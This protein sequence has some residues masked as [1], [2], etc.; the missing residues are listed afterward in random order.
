MIKNS[1]S[2]IRKLFRATALLL[3]L[4]MMLNVARAEVPQWIWPAAKAEDNEVCFFRKT[5]NLDSSF[6][7]AVLSATADDEIIVFV[8][9]QQVVDRK[10]WHAPERVDI[11]QHLDG[12][13]NVIAIRARNQGGD[14]AMIAMVE[15][16]R[17][18]KPKEFLYSD[19][20]WVCSKT[21]SPKWKDA[22]FDEAGWMKPVSRGKLG[23]EPWGNI[24][25]LPVATAVENITVPK[26][27]KVELLKSSEMGEGSWVSMTIDPKGRLIV[28]PQDGKNNLLRLTLGEKGEVKTTEKIDLPV[29]SAMGLLYAFDSLYV[30][31]A[32]PDGLGIYRLFDTKHQDKFDKVT[33][34]KKIENAGGEHGSHGMVLGADKHLYVIS[35]NFTSVP[36]DIS[37]NSQHK[38]YQEDQLLPR[39]LDGN[40]FGNEVKPPGGF[41]LRTDADGKEWE[42]YAAGMRNTY[43]VAVSAEGEIMAFD[44]DMEWDWGMPWYRPIRICHLVSGGDYGFREGT[45]KW[46]KYYPDSLPSV[47]DVGIGSPTG[48]KFGT[49]SKFPEP[50]RKA[51]YAMDWTYGRIFAVHLTP[52]GASYDGKVETFLKGKPLNVT[53]MEFGKDG[54]MYFI[55]GGRGTQSGL[56]RVTYV[57]TPEAEP[58]L[59]KAEK[60]AEKTA[61]KAREL[62]HKIERFHGHADPKALDFVWRHLDSPDRY[63]RYA[64]RIAVESQPVSQWQKRALSETRTNAALTSLLALARLGDKSC[65][66]ELLKALA[67]FP[68]DGLTEEQKLEKLRVIEVSFARQGRPEPAMVQLAIEKLDRQYPARTEALNRELCELL[69]YLRAP[70][71]VGKTLSLMDAAPTLEEQT[72]YIFHLRTLK[73]GWTQLQREHYFSWLQEHSPNHEAASDQARTTFPWIRKVAE[74]KDHT[75]ETLSWFAAAG[76]DYGDG[77]SYPG[78][79]ENIR[80][81]AGETLTK[82]QKDSLAALIEAPKPRATKPAVEHKFVK[83]WTMDELQSQLEKVAKGRSF[84]SGK[85]VFTSAQCLQ[86]HRFGNEGGAVGPD[87]TAVSSR[88]ARRDIL[89]SILLPSKVLSEQFQN[90]TFTKK[91]GDDVVGRVVEENDQKLV[92]MTNP[93]NQTKVDLLKADIASR[94]PSKLSPMPEGLMNNYKLEEILDLIAYLEAAGKSEA[95]NFK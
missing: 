21:E 47:V 85:E 15:I 78:F 50:Y 23:V 27:F 95:A 37:L 56:Y 12:G 68:L 16:T 53:D 59:S 60:A 72:H 48:M 41:L 36:K 91:D 86:C 17:A 93:L 7:K 63:L 25:E 26:G 42:L 22:D 79:I 51:L 24:F 57:G 30:N 90:T 5:F 73:E 70:G 88:F 13:K 1:L 69:I 19:D 20:S 18:G 77:A 52:N 33:T 43:D 40:G 29:G 67:K 31:G 76:R 10:D 38:N 28:S 87:L 45:G 11:T 83:D 74:G 75:E 82:A 39:G 49:G 65:Q 58:V 6:R 35:G 3:P 71:V 80:K 81:D 62:R 46:P 44:S 64:A 8:N 54:A 55:T 34:F 61:K 92:V 9:G 32:G 66:T 2:R 4:L 84:A 14:A 89:E 94:Q